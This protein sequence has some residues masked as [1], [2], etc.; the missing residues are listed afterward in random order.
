MEILAETLRSRS[1][2]TQQ[3]ALTFRSAVTFTSPPW[4]TW[5]N[6]LQGRFV[7]LCRVGGKN[8]AQTKS[9]FNADRL[10]GGR[11]DED[12]MGMRTSPQKFSGK[13]LPFQPGGGWRR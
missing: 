3:G 11:G 6:W 13:I 5:E 7:M 9:H 1:S 8:D 12:E 10:T 4:E 2:P